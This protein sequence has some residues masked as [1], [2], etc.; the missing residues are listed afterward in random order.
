M[1]IA[2]GVG[3]LLAIAPAAAANPAVWARLRTPDQ[4]YFVLM[5]HAL[6]PGTGDPAAFTLNDCTTQRNLSAE[7]RAQAEQTGAAFRAEGVIAGAV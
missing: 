7:G 4:A 6:A 1:K 5:R 2:A 3:L